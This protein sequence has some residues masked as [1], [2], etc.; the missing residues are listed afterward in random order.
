[1]ASVK[2]AQS[3]AEAGLSYME[4]DKA[5]DFCERLFSYLAKDAGYWNQ[6][7]TFEI[8]TPRSE[9]QKYITEELERIFLEEGLAF[10][11]SEGLVR[12]RG[13]KHTEDQAARA[14]V[15]LGDSRLASARKHYEKALKFFSHPSKP[16]YENCVKEAVCSIEATGK[17]LFQIAKAATL[18]E[19]V[20]WF[21]S[22]KEYGIPKALLKTIE[23]IY[24]YRNGGDGGVGH[25]G[26]TG[27]VATL[28][29]AEYVLSVAASQIIYL[30]DIEH[31]NED[32]PF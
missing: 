12:R 27:G 19:L 3:D 10:E 31:S 28:E 4:W 16:D 22:T 9:I 18:G 8:T 25:R 23:G 6:F 13:R 30:V 29:V 17:A 32:I 2:E 15:V 24:A 14:Q 21:S 11:F 20:K 7:E 1:M 26:A 5:Y